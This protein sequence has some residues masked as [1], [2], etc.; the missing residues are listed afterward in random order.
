MG[1]N[2]IRYKLT[3][4]D[5][6]GGCAICGKHCTE[7]FYL[8]EER[9]FHIPARNGYPEIDSW[10]YYGA[11]NGIGHKECLEDKIAEQKVV[12]DIFEAMEAVDEEGN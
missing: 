9:R 3:T 10:T 4:L 2:R 11:W 5:D 7:A 12:G 8:H 1:D 6:S